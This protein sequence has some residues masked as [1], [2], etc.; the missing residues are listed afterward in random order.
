[1]EHIFTPSK[2]IKDVRGLA[3][4]LIPT[5]APLLREAFD[6]P[7]DDLLIFE[8][9]RGGFSCGEIAGATGAT[10]GEIGSHPWRMTVVDGGGDDGHSLFV[11]DVAELYILTNDADNDE[12][13][14][15]YCYEPLTGNGRWAC[16]AR[17]KVNTA[18]TC[19]LFFGFHNYKAAGT[20]AQTAGLGGSASGFHMVDGAAAV[21]IIASS[22]NGT[23]TTTDT[24]T[25]LADDTYVTLSLFHDNKNG[26]KFYVNGTLAATHTPSQTDLGTTDAAP[27]I[28][29][30]NASAAASNCSV[31]YMAFWVE[32]APGFSGNA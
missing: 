11:T 15:Q 21:D 16:E 3:N 24:G 27:T 20:I 17:I 5:D 14:I 6:R 10:T 23:P 13:A 30:A 8:D 9:F 32:D 2:P 31:D 29:F 4:G 25:N 28:A 7:S 12:N 26:T 19:A 1:M 22:D 18:A